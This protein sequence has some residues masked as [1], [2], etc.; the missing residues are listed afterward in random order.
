M[1]REPCDGSAGGGPYNVSLVGGDLIVVNHVEVGLGDWR[2]NSVFYQ[3]EDGIRVLVRSRGLGDVYKRQ[4][5][6]QEADP[7]GAG[8]GVAPVSVARP[9]A[10]AGGSTESGEKSSDCDDELGTRPSV[11]SSGIGSYALSADV[12]VQNQHGYVLDLSLIHI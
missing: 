2:D 12:V 8:G 6:E 4:Q 7:G 9:R 3:A 1:E 10:A 5:P 11:A